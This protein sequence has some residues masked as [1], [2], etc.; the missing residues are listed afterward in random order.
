MKLR[1]YASVSRDFSR[2]VRSLAVSVSLVAVGVSTGCTEA[3]D[4]CD[5]A[6]RRR[7]FQL[8]IEPL[9]AE[10]RTHTCSQCH[11]TGLDLTAY[12]R[13]TPCETF[14]CLRQQNLVDVERP[15]ESRVL[16]W[17][18]R[19]QP[20]S[21]LITTEV[22]E[23]EREALSEWITYNSE[24]ATCDQV[25]C[26][27]AQS[28]DRC[29]P[30]WPQ[31][32]LEENDPGDCSDDTLY[33]VFHEAVYVSRGRCSPCHFNESTFDSRGAPPW[34][35]VFGDCKTASKQTLWNLLNEGYIDA[36]NPEAS[37][38][39]T[40]PLPPDQGGVPHGG[41]EKFDDK[42]DL[43]YVAFRY[44]A[45]RMAECRPSAILRTPEP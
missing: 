37:L 12:V 30:E 38:L 9:L 23:E 17:I 33:Q 40:K 29:T 26:P 6:S 3:S 13:D 8:R 24:C 32:E 14:A 2:L 5:E 44:F 42:E 31:G 10:G 25:E 11:L 19:A 15:E 4:T 45:E 36:E 7:E 41:H 35:E 39:L 28:E 20:D 22:I 18:G 43:D 1:H 34:I 27:D 16:S 21:K